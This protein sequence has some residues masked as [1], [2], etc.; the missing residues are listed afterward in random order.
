MTEKIFTAMKSPGVKCHFKNIYLNTIIA[1][2]SFM[3][4]LIQI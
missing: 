2:D 4:L 3:K 1:I